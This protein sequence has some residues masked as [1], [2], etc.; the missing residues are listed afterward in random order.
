MDRR[1]VAHSSPL[2]GPGDPERRARQQTAVADL[3]QLDLGGVS[4]PD[5]YDAVARETALALGI[6]LAKVAL[7]EPETGL[8]R[9][10]AGVGWAP[11]VVGTAVLPA[12][13]DTP[14]GAA[15]R[16][17]EPLFVADT[18]ALRVPAPALLRDHRV[19]SGVG[20]R[21]GS[22]PDAPYGLFSLHHTVPHAFD[23]PERVFVR[24]IALVLGSAV[25][26]DRDRE[27]IRQ[28]TASLEAYFEAVPVGVAILDAEH[29]YVRV[30]GRLAALAGRASDDLVGGSMGIASRP[31]GG[32]TVTI[33]APAYPWTGHN[34]VFP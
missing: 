18:A 20:I 3:A 32:T 30:N 21:F 11:G 7:W 14:A 13:P 17:A 27:T 12:G 26:R 1:P 19:R 22:D 34:R 31:G 8:L 5:I 29:R 10:V 2:V 24:T 4:L 15:L 9:V 25:A 28:R 23:E 33:E 16:S 6:P